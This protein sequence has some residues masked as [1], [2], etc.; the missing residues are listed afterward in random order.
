VDWK[1]VLYSVAGGS[2]SVL[3]LAHLMSYFSTKCHSFS[4]YFTGYWAMLVF[5]IAIAYDRV[6]SGLDTDRYL[7]IRSN[8]LDFL[9]FGKRYFDAK[10]NEVFRSSER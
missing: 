8:F 5:P 9:C 7:V 2:L 3:T 1:D 6:D 4:S 10:K